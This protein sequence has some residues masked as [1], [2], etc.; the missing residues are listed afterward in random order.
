MGPIGPANSDKWPSFR[1]PSSDSPRSRLRLSPSRVGKR[2]DSTPRTHSR[3]ARWH[4]GGHPAAPP[5]RALETEELEGI[6]LPTLAEMARIKACL[7]ATRHTTRDYLDSV[8]LCEPR[9][10]WRGEG[11]LAERVG[12]GLR[13]CPAGLASGI[14]VRA[15]GL[16][17]CL[18]GG[19][20]TR[21]QSSRHSYAIRDTYH[22]L[23]KAHELAAR[24][25]MAWARWRR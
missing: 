23:R 11:H 21:K 13:Y 12:T 9:R 22:V 10:C 14:P 20:A 19:S 5:H 4:S 6:Q 18:P 3:H 15:A 24:R 2:R 17:A 25:S 7:L 16:R 8:V 1:S